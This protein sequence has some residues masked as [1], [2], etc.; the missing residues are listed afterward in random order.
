MIFLDFAKHRDFDALRARRGFPR[1]LRHGSFFA[2][3]S[4]FDA[5]DPDC[6]AIS[7]Y[8]HAGNLCRLF[9]ECGETYYEDDTVSITKGCLNYGCNNECVY[10]DC[11][12]IRDGMAMLDEC[13]VCDGPGAIYEC[14]CEE[15][16]ECIVEYPG[17]GYELDCECLEV[18]PFNSEIEYFAGL[19]DQY[20]AYCIQMTK[21]GCYDAFCSSDI[22][23]GCTNECNSQEV[24]AGNE[25][26]EDYKQWVD[27]YVELV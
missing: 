27:Y 26:V 21:P 5:S 12:G 17:A 24:I 19:G 14:G 10:V 15:M 23:D 18:E 22:W 3:A 16:G 8:Y 11:N 1:A 7:F 25:N 20:Y 13:G 4:I 2:N 6:G 9:T